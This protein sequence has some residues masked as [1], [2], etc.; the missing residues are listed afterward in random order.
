MNEWEG[1]E[2]DEGMGDGDT[3]M[4]I[5]LSNSGRMGEGMTEVE[6]GEGRGFYGGGCGSVDRC[7]AVTVGKERPLWGD[8]Q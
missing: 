6:S 3:E 5:G 8:C 1:W 2:W 7:Q 4:N